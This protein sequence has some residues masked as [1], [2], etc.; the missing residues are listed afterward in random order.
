MYPNPTKGEIRIEGVSQAI[1]YKLFNSTGQVILQG[2]AEGDLR[3]EPNLGKGI[4][5]LEISNS[6]G[7]STRKIV[8]E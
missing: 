8:V 3:M 1:G 2:M 7:V 5:F 6:L 4:Y